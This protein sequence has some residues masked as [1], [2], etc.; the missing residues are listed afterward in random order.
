MDQSAFDT[1]PE[2][3]GA[4][5]TFHETVLFDRSG[6]LQGGL[7]ETLPAALGAL[8][9]AAGSPGGPGRASRGGSPSDGFHTQ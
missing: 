5:E 8:E 2:L 9:A 4:F 6:T 7:P 1:L 3:L